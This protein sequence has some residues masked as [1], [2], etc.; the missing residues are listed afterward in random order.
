MHVHILLRAR[1]EALLSFQP[2][3]TRYR[4]SLKI[5]G[6][7]PRTGGVEPELMLYPE[8]GG[9][10]TLRPV[11]PLTGS[12]SG[13]DWSVSFGMEPAQLMLVAIYPMVRLRIDPW[14]GPQ[15]IELDEGSLR[16]RLR[17]AAR[18]TMGIAVE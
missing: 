7:R 14:T 16:A 2:F 1:T 6:E 4:L 11:L 8:G 13:R 12:P 15:G 17:M 3:G 5:V 9:L 10:L 18:M